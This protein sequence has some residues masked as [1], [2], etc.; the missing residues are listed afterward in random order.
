MGNRILA[1]IE[2]LNLR[3][4][5]VSPE[6]KAEADAIAVF[7]V[8]EVMALQNLKSNAVLGNRLSLEEGMTVYNLLGGETALPG[9]IN[10]QDLATRM[11]LL[12]L[13][14]EL[15]QPAGKKSR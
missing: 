9:H 7:T 6:E 1:S 15:S 13:L 14:T 2:R 5:E 8:T 4:A 3:I 12:T 11:T 10:A